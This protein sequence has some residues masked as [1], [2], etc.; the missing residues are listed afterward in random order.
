VRCS[1]RLYEGSP[2]LGICRACDRRQAP[3]ARSVPTSPTGGVLPPVSRG[4]GDTIA[5]VI[6]YHDVLDR[7][8]VTGQQGADASFSTNLSDP[9]TLFSFTGY[10][11]RGN[12]TIG[13][14]PRANTSTQDFDGASRHIAAHRQMRAG[15]SGTGAIVA[16]ITTATTLDGNG[17]AT[18]LTDANSNTTG[19]QFDTLDRKTVTTLPDGSTQTT[20]YN[21]ASDVITYTDENGSVFDSSA[22]GNYDAKGRRWTL[23]VTPAGGIGGTTQQTF[24]HDGLSRMVNS[25]DIAGGVAATAGKTFDSLGRVVEEAQQY[26]GAAVQYVTNTAFTSLPSTELTY[27][28]ARAIG[29]TF[30][31]LY[32]RFL[33]FEGASII[34][35]WTFVGPARVADQVLGN[36]ITCSYLN[37]AMANSAVQPAVPNPA[38]S[39]T[40]GDRLGYDGAG[41]LIGKRYFGQC[42]SS[43]SSS[44]SSSS[45]RSSRSSS[46]RS[47]RSSSSTACCPCYQI[48]TTLDPSAPPIVLEYAGGGTWT[49]GTDS[50]F[51][52]SVGEGFTLTLNA[53]PGETVYAAAGPC[54]PTDPASWTFISGNPFLY[55]IKCCPPRVLLRQ[56]RQR[57]KQRLIRLGVTF[58][59]G[60]RGSG[61]TFGVES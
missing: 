38:W 53:G 51:I 16:T 6:T 40:C 33:I 46:S 20:Q 8:V 12:A 10:D 15:G 30:D 37:N 2:H 23:N 21:D 57:P 3:T 31:E 54:P 22:A 4:L 26:A 18:A 11:S 49:D 36:G 58:G 27:P 28:N 41:R 7:P 48:M 29:S 55:G 43:S 47:S 34:T 32:R 61:V 42:N 45:S 44:Q 39:N 14:D 24:A 59:V 25:N 52:I 9:G 5:K 60:G 1:L 35:D 13:I 19:Y 17:R 56:R 50:N